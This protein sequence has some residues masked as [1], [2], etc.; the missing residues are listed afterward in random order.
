M[1]ALAPYTCTE[2]A[3][4]LAAVLQAACDA[5]GL[6]A[7]FP[8]VG[9]LVGMY[10]GSGPAPTDFDQAKTTD[11]RAYAA[12]FHAMLNRGVAFAPGAYEVV[13]CCVPHSK[14]ELER[15]TDLASAAA[16]EVADRHG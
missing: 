14:D 5:A 6:P 15:V 2:R 3:A 16:R 8:V 10:F 11:E 7:S 12:F 9:T 1:G 13:F 4:R